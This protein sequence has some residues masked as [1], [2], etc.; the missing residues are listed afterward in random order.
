MNGQNAIDFF[1]IAFEE[2]IS[3]LGDAAEE[4]AG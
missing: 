1:K 3:V 2:K 4:N